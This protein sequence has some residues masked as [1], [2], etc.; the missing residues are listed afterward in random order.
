MR[1][2]LKK[3]VT[4]TT[5]FSLLFGIAAVPADAAAKKPTLASSSIT[6]AIGAKKTVKIKN[7]VKG[8]TISAASKDKKLATV[9][10]KPA[11]GKSSAIVVTGKNVGSTKVTVKVKQ[12]K[13]TYKLTLSVKVKISTKICNELKALIIK[14]DIANIDP[15]KNL[16]ANSIKHRHTEND[17]DFGCS[18]IGEGEEGNGNTYADTFYI[19]ENKTAGAEATTNAIYRNYIQQTDGLR[20]NAFAFKQNSFL[21]KYSVKN[22]NTSFSLDQDTPFADKEE[23]SQVL[24]FL[25]EIIEIPIYADFYFK[26]ISTFPKD[27]R[28]IEKTYHKGSV[29]YEFKS[30]GKNVCMIFYAEKGDDLC[31]YL[32]Y[33]SMTDETAKIEDAYGFYYKTKAQEE[34]GDTTDDIFVYPNYTP[35]DK[36]VLGID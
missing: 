22:D 13:K 5:V 8:T 21:R 36:A 4:T 35:A 32:S 18:E 9:K 6:V 1:R 10:C 25:N 20:Y 16:V 11:K 24:L 15:E 12:N 23:M 33:A 2:I 31:D 27:D 34:K 14:N 29:I 26:I 17:V 19:S 7:A 30:E 3:I 28:D